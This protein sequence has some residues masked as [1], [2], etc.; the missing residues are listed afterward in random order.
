MALAQE[1]VPP[2]MK[3]HKVLQYSFVG[4]IG[5]ILLVYV[6]LRVEHMMGVH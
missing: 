5:L 6:M 4:A 3:A 1:M 2:R